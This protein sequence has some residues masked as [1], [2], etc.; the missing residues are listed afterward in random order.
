MYLGAGS[1][2]LDTLAHCYTPHCTPEPSPYVYKRKAQG[3]RT[4]GLVARENGPLS[5]SPTR[6]LV[7]PYCKRTRPGRRTTRRPRFPFCCLLPPFVSR[8]APTHL[9]WG[10]RRQFTRRSRDPPGSK[11][12]HVHIRWVVL[13]HIC[14][15]EIKLYPLKTQC[16]LTDMKLYPYPHSHG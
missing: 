16:L 7:T 1:S 15:R 3:S 12:R 4:R 10:T 11:C 5:L 2:Q 8:L 9:G 6:T 13:T 14:T